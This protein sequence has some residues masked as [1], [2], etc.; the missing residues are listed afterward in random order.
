[1]ETAPD[2]GGEY[3]FVPAEERPPEA[4]PSE[5][6]GP[7][8][9]P[10]APLDPAPA[11]RAAGIFSVPLVSYLEQGK[12]YLQIGAY[13]YAESVE[14]ELSKLGNTYPLSVQAGDGPPLYRIL[15]GPVNMGECGALLQRFKTIGYTDAFIR[16]IDSY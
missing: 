16:L 8:I 5:I 7:A 13:S 9:A 6:P 1:M 3:T 12:Y 2:T 14:A 4:V 10:I 15:V 11:D